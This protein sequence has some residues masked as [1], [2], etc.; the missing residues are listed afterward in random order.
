MEEVLS[1]YSLFNRW[2]G[3]LSLVSSSRGFYNCQ[4]A[5]FTGYLGYAFGFWGL[6]KSAVGDSRR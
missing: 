5:A 4:E 3:V 2:K 1:G 6:K